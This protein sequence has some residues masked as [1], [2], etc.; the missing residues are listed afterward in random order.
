[1]SGVRSSGLAVPQESALS[2]SAGC[3]MLG[4]F[5]AIGKY[6]EP[7]QEVAPVRIDLDLELVTHFEVSLSDRLQG[8]DLWFQ[9]LLET[10]TQTGLQ[11]TPIAIDYLQLLP[12]DT[13]GNILY[14]VF[15]IPSAWVESLQTIATLHHLRLERVGVLPQNC[16]IDVASKSID[17][18]PHRQRQWQQQY[19]HWWWSSA[20]ALFAGILTV[21]V[22]H[23]ARAWW[24]TQEY[25]TAEQR[26]AT[27][28][29]V[30]QLQTQHAQLTQTL[31]LS[32]R[33][34]QQ[35]VQQTTWQ[36]RHEK[37]LQVLQSI[38]PRMWLQQL[39]LDGPTWRLKGQA[40]S[41][42]DVQGLQSRLQALTIWQQ[43]PKV[44]RLVLLSAS[45]SARLPVWEFE[46]MAVL[47]GFPNQPSSS[48][49]PAP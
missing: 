10:Q 25:A 44:D 32:T 16:S 23:A 43:A 11:D 37:W 46:L 20:L 1:M 9:L 18:L 47:Q 41:E 21:F 38:P 29:A 6:M 48:S 12:N 36:D 39:L 30:T 5:G 24:V 28:Q 27:L 13:S 26:M 33:K 19:N 4:R 42:L 2:F 45:D 31:E 14:R 34:H 7:A 17:F 8:E 49:S 22:L 3:D 40:L 15:A 35:W